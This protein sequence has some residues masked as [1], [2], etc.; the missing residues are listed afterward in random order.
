MTSER[1]DTSQAR[2]PPESVASAR[3]R[4]MKGMVAV[5]AVLTLHSGSAFAMASNARCVDN[6]VN[7]PV[8]PSYQAGARPSDTYVRVRLWS[9][10]PD[11]YSRDVRWYVKGSD[12]EALVVGN[13]RVDNVFMYPGEWKQFDPANPTKNHPKIAQVPSWE[14]WPGTRGVMAQDGG[15]VAVRVDATGNGAD[16]IGI[17]GPSSDGSAI[18]ASCWTSVGAV[19]GRRKRNR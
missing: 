11:A 4:L 9:L 10:R 12:I 17:V 7:D 13:N 16:I 19:S 3:R 15:W 5:P 6:Q 18:T 2:V 8:Y 14:P 1:D